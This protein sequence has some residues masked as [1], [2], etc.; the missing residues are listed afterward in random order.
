MTLEKI[1]AAEIER[2]EKNYGVNIQFVLIARDLTTG[3]ITDCTSPMSLGMEID[4][5]RSVTCRCH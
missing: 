5:C 3:H 1:L 4:L 2:L